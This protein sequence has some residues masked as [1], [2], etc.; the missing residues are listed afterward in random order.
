[1]ATL[2]TQLT[3]YPLV[4]PAP[5]LPLPFSPPLHFHRHSYT[6]RQ[7]RC[8]L[9]V[10]IGLAV[11][12]ALL[13]ALIATAAIHGGS[14]SMADGR[15]GDMPAPPAA[16]P[17]AGQAG[18]PAADPGQGKAGGQAVGG[19]TA[20]GSTGAADSQGGA[21]GEGGP[22]SRK[23]TPGG[24][25]APMEG[26]GGQLCSWAQYRLPSTVV[27]LYYNLTLNVSMTDPFPVAGEV[28][29]AVNV[30]QVSGSERVVLCAVAWAA[31][32]F[33]RIKKFKKVWCS[34]LPNG[35][36]SLQRCLPFA[37]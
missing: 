19:P 18:A 14:R 7:R 5:L 36:R 2:V 20:A 25:A 8:I 11:L 9:G 33:W 35:T 17:E 13:V 4:C 29:I 15:A 12:L 27:P 32:L 28:A 10:G 16:G 24:Q 23:P 22:G 34:C 37:A 30:T 26:G 3:K 1:M 6:K 31:L 21:A